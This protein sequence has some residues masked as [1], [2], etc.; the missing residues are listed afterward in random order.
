MK[1]KNPRG[2]GRLAAIFV[3]IAIATGCNVIFGIDE[4]SLP[5]QDTRAGSNDSG[6]EGPSGGQK[7]YGK[8]NEE[9]QEGGGGASAG[10]GLGVMGQSGQG[11]GGLGGMGTAGLGGQGGGGSGGLPPSVPTLL[12]AGGQHTCVRAQGVMRC[13]GR[14]ADGELGYSVNTT[15]NPVPALV[16]SGVLTGVHQPVLGNGQSCALRDDG[17]VF[18]WGTNLYGQL[19]NSLNVGT[20][21][22]NPVPILVDDGTLGVVR[23]L[24]LGANHSCALRNDGRVLCWGRNNY[25]QLGIGANIGTNIPNPEPTLIDDSNL[26]SVRQVALGDLHSCALRDD[27]RVFCWGANDFGQLG[28]SVNAGTDN[29]NVPILVDDSNL[30]TVRQL[31]L[32][33]SHSCAIRDDGRVF[34]W[35]TNL[36]GQLGSSVNVGT[37]N[38]TPVPTPIDNGSLGVARQ[39]GLGSR[40]SC[41]VHEDGRLFCWGYNRYGQLGSSVNVDTDNATSTPTLVD[42]SSLSITRQVALGSRHSCA[43]RDDGRVFCWGTNLFGQ[44]GNTVNVGTLT[45]NDLPTSVEALPLLA[46]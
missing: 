1:S 7:G 28:T 40:H 38:A 46:P 45:A 3:P 20:S 36:Y 30:G 24:A 22:P 35:G 14:N 6:M 10:G 33:S 43:V 2:L 31:A 19:G 16:D 41:A 17:R 9:E 15:P 34:C 11:N 44:L 42:L 5:A 21:T 23:Q 27:G 4:S 12:A 8:G 18:C 37:D 39:I 29:A 26:G 32:G 25:G 13:W